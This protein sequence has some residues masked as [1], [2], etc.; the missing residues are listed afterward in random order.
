MSALTFAPTGWDVPTFGSETVPVPQS[1]R[2]SWIEWSMPNWIHMPAL[3]FRVTPEPQIQAIQLVAWTEL[4]LRTLAEML[5]TTH[6]TLSA[7][8]R[9]QSTDL[10]KRPY[11]IDGI[12][13]LHDLSARLHPLVGTPR[14]LGEV[15]L[16]P[17][18]NASSIAELAIGGSP[19]RAYVEALRLIAPRKRS[20]MKQSFATRI[21]GTA[22]VPLAD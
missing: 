16:A 10:S 19:A 4:S 21:E 11:V 20:A 12:S 7:L 3:G 13:V 14:E 1:P 2:R 5:G 17:A 8:L 15:L 9:G 18:P 22:T 6:P